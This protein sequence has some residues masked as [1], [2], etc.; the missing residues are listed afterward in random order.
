M[1]VDV[2]RLHAVPDLPTALIHAVAKMMP[3]VLARRPNLIVDE[4]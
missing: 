3:T 2:Y 4:Y 1:G